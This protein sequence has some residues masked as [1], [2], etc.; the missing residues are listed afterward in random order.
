MITE[1]DRVVNGPPNTYTAPLIG[2]RNRGAI[3]GRSRSGFGRF[4]RRAIT[5]ERPTNF[6]DFPCDGVVPGPHPAI[7]IHRGNP[8]LRRRSLDLREIV[9]SL[10]FNDEMSVWICLEADDEI[11]NVVVR[12]AVVDVRDGEAHAGVLYKRL[13]GRVRVDDVGSPLFPRAG[14]GDDIVHV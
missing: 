6:L 3:T 8:A 12:L 10:G 4:A 13:D 11:R 9:E 14:V 5:I 7:G 1:H 2:T